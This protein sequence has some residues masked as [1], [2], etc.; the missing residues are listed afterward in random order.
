MAETTENLTVLLELKNAEFERNAR[1][2]G[3]AID[4]LERKLDPLA[5]AE[6]KLEKQQRRFNAAL[7]AGTIDTKA[8]AKGMDL[9]QREYDQTIERANR[10]AGATANLNKAVSGQAGFMARNR[11]VFQQAGYQIGDF[12]VQ[13]QGGQSAITAFTQQ[14]SQLLG[15]FGAYGA[16]AGAVLAVGAPIIS[17]FLRSGENAATYEDALKD[18]TEALG[19]YQA[20]AQQSMESTDQLAESF[21]RSGEMVRGSITLLR[22][23][24]LAEALR[25][26]QGAAA[27]LAAEYENIFSI[28]DDQN[29]GYFETFMIADVELARSEVVKLRDALATVGEAQGPEQIS[30]AMRGMYATLI[31]VYGTLE[32]VPPAFQ[33]IAQ[34]AATVDVEVAKLKNTIDSTKVSVFE[35]VDAAYAAGSAFAAAGGPVDALLG[36]V[37]NLAAA[38]WNYAGAMGEASAAGAARGPD[39]AVTDVRGELTPTGLKRSDIVLQKTFSTPARISSRGGGGG[40]KKRSGGGGSSRTQTPLFSSTMDDLQ[41]LDRQIEMIGKSKSEVAGLTAKYKLL[42]EAKKRG[43]NLDAKQAST[44]KTLSETI[45]EKSQAMARLTEEYERAEKSQNDFESGV[46]SIS[47]ALAGAIVDGEDWRESMRDIFRGLAK[48][49]IASGIKQSLLSVFK[50]PKA[51]GGGFLSSL[52]GGGGLGGLLS[53][54]GGGSTGTGARSG[55]VDGKGGFPAILHPN[56]TVIDHTKSA[57]G[58]TSGGRLVVELSSELKAQIVD[59]AAN[60]TVQLIQQAAPAIQ[61]GAVRTVHDSMRKNPQFGA[62]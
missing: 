33:E 16:V 11:N 35:I 42:D 52:F 43:L 22:E 26:A 41:N 8:H 21:G 62:A 39:G 29:A 19:A 30:D 28:L 12:A 6:A 18:L 3:A 58:G 46:D 10:A 13:I 14:G 60:Q 54:D 32:D 1:S 53:F 47:D 51:G 61:S 50:T 38:A 37:Q 4:R 55:G 9:L 59:E 36:K 44:G 15:V 24:A 31:D 5:A 49:I 48:D 27:A 45:D 23:L 7:K 56:E 20:L 40:S 2:S 25:T 34:K 17:T 57:S